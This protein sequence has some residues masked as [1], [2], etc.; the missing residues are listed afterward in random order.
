MPMLMRISP[1]V[2][3]NCARSSLES[4][5]C[6]MLAGCD[7]SV[8]VVPSDTA[9]VHIFSPSMNF[10]PASR[11]PF[12][13]MLIM[14]PGCRIC[15]EHTR[16]CGCEERAV[17]FRHYGIHPLDVFA[18]EYAAD[19]GAMAIEKLGGAVKYIVYAVTK[20]LLQ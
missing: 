15:L 12:S 3:P 7:I 18:N 1:S 19:G 10:L 14:G 17:P 13:S 6:D 5:K 11:P 20:R 16:K 4:P 9:R 8:S 2:I